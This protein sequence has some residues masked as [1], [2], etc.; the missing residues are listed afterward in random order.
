MSTLL[1]AHLGLAVIKTAIGFNLLR[2]CEGMWSWYR[3]LVWAVLWLVWVYT[4]IFFV[5]NLQLCTPLAKFWDLKI[6][7]GSCTHPLVYA[8]FGQANSGLNIFTDMAL[9]V[10]PVPIIWRIKLPV[11]VRL[12]LIGVLS[13]GYLS[14]VFGIIKT[15]Y[16][17]AFAREVDRTYNIAVPFW[18]L[19]VLP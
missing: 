1:I 10:I 5:R 14:V 9:A 17:V 11:R 4:T 7:D 6:K 8:Q 19:Q 12:T 18:S 13:L 2:F 3:W 16:Q 15:I